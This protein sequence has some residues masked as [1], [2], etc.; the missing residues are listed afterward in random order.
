MANTRIKSNQG[1]V[2]SGGLTSQV[3]YKVSGSD[4]DYDWGASGGGSQWTDVGADIQFENTVYIGANESDPGLPGWVSILPNQGLYNKDGNA[5]AAYILADDT[6][7]FA[8]ETLCADIGTST[9][10][11][12]LNNFNLSNSRFLYQANKDATGQD[13]FHVGETSPLTWIENYRADFVADIAGYAGYSFHNFNSG[14][15]SPTAV[16]DVGASTTAR[17]SLRL[18]SG[19]APTTPNDGDIW[20]D[21]TDLKIRISGATKTVTVT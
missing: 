14:S 7:Y 16:V 3:L 1:G 21:G 6:Y 8:G 9:F 11:S 18:R 10:A 13:Y 2:P 17:S 15:T 12:T 4:Y 20:F 5:I 19:T